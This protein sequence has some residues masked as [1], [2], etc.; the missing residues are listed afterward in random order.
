M[1]TYPIRIRRETYRG[2]DRTRQSRVVSQNSQI[3]DLER[4]INDLLFRQEESIQV[5]D[6]AD[7]ARGTGFPLDFVSEVGYSIDG[8]SNG[9]TAWRRGMTYDEAIAANKRLGD[10]S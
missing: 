10:E 7:I 1:V 9:F 2:R 8:G 6:F 3:A 4:Y 5:Y